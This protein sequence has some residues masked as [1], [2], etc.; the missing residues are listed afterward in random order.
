MSDATSLGKD[1]KRWKAMK[2]LGRNDPCWCGSG[3]K[4][5]KCHLN[6]SLQEKGNPW[7]AVAANK[8]GF[9][10]RN[11]ALKVLGS[12]PARARSSRLIP[13]HAVQI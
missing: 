6:R 7:D 13:F 12:A 10:R 1:G 9:T 11:A 4:Y 3:Q 5:K 8:K 2:G